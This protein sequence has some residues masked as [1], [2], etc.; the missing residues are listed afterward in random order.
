MHDLMCVFHLAAMGRIDFS[1]G[2]KWLGDWLGVTVLSLC[3]MKEAWTR[4][5]LWRGK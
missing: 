2:P 3:E 5:Q 1:E 4:G